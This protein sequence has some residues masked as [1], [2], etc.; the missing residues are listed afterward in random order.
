MKTAVSFGRPVNSQ[1]AMGKGLRVEM[2][3]KEPVT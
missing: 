2:E 3:G 1:N